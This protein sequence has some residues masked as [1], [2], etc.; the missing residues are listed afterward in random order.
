MKRCLKKAEQSATS[1]MTSHTRKQGG[2]HGNLAEV[3]SYSDKITHE[4]LRVAVC[5]MVED[6]ILGR[7][8]RNAFLFP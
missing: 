1:D 2:Q 4:V 6:A 3:N 8:E 7:V 5:R